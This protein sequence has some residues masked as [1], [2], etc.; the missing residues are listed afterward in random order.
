MRPVLR[1][2]EGTGRAETILWGVNK[3]LKKASSVGFQLVVFG[4]G[5]GKVAVAAT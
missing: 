5:G 3:G 2:H 1:R 4:G